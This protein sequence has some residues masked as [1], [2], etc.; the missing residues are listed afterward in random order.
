MGAASPAFR[1]R[2]VEGAKQTRAGMKSPNEVEAKR[3]PEEPDPKGFH[4]WRGTPK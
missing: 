2:D 4:P 3:S 1:V